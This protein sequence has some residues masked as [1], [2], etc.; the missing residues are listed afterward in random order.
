MEG[1]TRRK[2]KGLALRLVADCMR[3]TL[4]LPS[5]PPHASPHLV[6]LAVVT[7]PDAVA[8][9]A[10]HAAVQVDGVAGV[11]D[12]LRVVEDKRRVCTPHS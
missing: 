2:I 5:P 3:V 9:L 4:S 8:P 7:L 1:K 12:Y 11:Y 6:D 10:P